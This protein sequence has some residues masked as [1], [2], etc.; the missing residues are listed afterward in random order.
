MKKK[1]FV[2][3]AALMMV[4][5]LNG[6]AFSETFSG[7]VTEV[8]G[9]KVTIEITEGDAEDIEVGSSVELEVEE[10]DEDE[11]GGMLQGC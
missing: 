2:I 1:L 8:K 11:G 3:A 9:D 7:E 10:A 6:F 4:A 5:G